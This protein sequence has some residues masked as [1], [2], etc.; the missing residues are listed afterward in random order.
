MLHFGYFLQAVHKRK[1]HFSTKI[2][3]DHNIVPFM[4]ILPQ[5]YSVCTRK[6]ASQIKGWLLGARFSEMYSGKSHIKM[7]RK[8]D[9]IDILSENYEKK[10]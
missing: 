8:L 10:L 9:L 3:K 2:V 6:S 1:V 5:Y 4:D 7:Q